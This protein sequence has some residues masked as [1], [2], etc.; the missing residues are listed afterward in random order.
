MTSWKDLALHYIQY[1]NT[2]W[3]VAFANN[4]YTWDMSTE[5][6]LVKPRCKS[7]AGLMLDQGPQRWTNIKPAM[8][9]VTLG[10]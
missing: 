9:Q 5:N 4:H 2:L 3:R 6:V 7:D 1:Y 10:Q 8:E